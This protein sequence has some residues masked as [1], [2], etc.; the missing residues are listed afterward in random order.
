MKKR[1]S[2]KKKLFYFFENAHLK[3]RKEMLFYEPAIIVLEVG[4]FAKGG[5]I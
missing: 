4:T 1:F 2:Q 5:F 3:K